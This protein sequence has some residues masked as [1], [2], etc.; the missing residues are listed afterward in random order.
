MTTVT[1]STDTEFDDI[2]SFSS[3]DSYK[4]EPFT[5][6][7]DGVPVQQDEGPNLLRND[8][9][10]DE[11]QKRNLNNSGSR[12]INRSTSRGSG[13]AD[14]SDVHSK[15][16]NTTLK[17]LDSNAVERMITHNAVQNNSETVESLKKQ[18]LGQKGAFLPDINS[19]LTHTSTHNAFPE[20][21]QIETTTGLVKLK[22]I[23]TMKNAEES[24]ADST[25]AKDDAKSE[26]EGPTAEEKIQKAIARNQKDIEKYQR[27]KNSSGL[28][29][30]IHKIFD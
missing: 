22:T 12:D 2:S 25:K 16:S 3:V 10:L 6:T 27:H 13:A 29:G 18:G 11:Q 24:G 30:M 26:N 8:T 28:M 15:V 4:P 5:G 17:K 9:I 20:E 1:S 23:E 14:N 21:Y 7:E 19:P